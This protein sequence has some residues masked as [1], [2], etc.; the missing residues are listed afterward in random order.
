[1]A[2]TAYAISP[3][4]IWITLHSQLYIKAYKNIGIALFGN[5]KFDVELT[6]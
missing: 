1:L 3:F 6:K 4:D 5:D 2:I